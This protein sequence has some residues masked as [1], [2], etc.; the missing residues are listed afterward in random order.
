[1]V[2]KQLQGG[3]HPPGEKQDRY[4]EEEHQGQRHGEEPG[5][6]VG[7]REEQHHQTAHDDDAH[8]LVQGFP[9]GLSLDCRNKAEHEPERD[10]RHAHGEG[11]IEHRYNGQ[12]PFHD[13]GAFQAEEPGPELTEELTVENTEQDGIACGNEEDLRRIPHHVPFLVDLRQDQGEDQEDEPVAGVTEDHAEKEREADGDERCRVQGSVAR[14]R[15]EPG[16]Q[17]EGAEIGGI[18]QGDRHQVEVLFQDLFLLHDH[19]AAE[20]SVPARRRSRATSASGVQP[21]MKKHMPVW[22]R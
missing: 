4:E 10:M 8:Q 20:S 1:M 19:F 12:P 15:Q 3:Q 9:S 7:H 18:A 14:Q 22:W 2:F 6:D 17:F 13:K 21:W 11:K 5:E 16:E